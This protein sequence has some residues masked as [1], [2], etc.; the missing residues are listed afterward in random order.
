MQALS[1]EISAAG[2][3]QAKAAGEEYMGSSI[4]S[5]LWS[6]LLL[7]DLYEPQDR[8]F[9]KNEMAGTAFFTENPVSNVKTREDECEIGDLD[10]DYD[11]FAKAPIK[12]AFKVKVKIKSVSRFQ[13]KVFIDE[14]ELNPFF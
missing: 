3:V 13:P 14:D 12:K 4:F 5:S 8:G 9:F 11:L 7:M 10:N 1:Y 2:I 6:T